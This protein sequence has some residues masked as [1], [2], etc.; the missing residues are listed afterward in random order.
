MATIASRLTLLA[1][2][3]CIVAAVLA[4]Y[5]R[6]AIL[7]PGH[8]ADRAVATLAQ[9]EVADEIATRFSTGVIERSPGLV[10]LRPA[11][12]AA[13]ADA[14]T[15]PR[16]AAEFGAGMRDLHR[17][18]F[19]GSD[20]RPALRVPGMAAAVRAAVAAR[21]PV[22]AQRL[23]VAADP[24][25]MS[26]GGNA[27]ERGLLDVASRAG[28][29]T[30]LAPVVLALGLLGLLLVAL[31]ARDRRRGLWASGLALA[32]A[33][34]TLV[35]GWM[36]ARTLTLQGFDTSWGD[37][38]VKTIWGAYLGDLRA[39]S[40][41]LA[42]AGILVAAAAARREHRERPS[43]A[44]VPAPLR[45]VAL[46]VTGAVVVA[47]RDLAL[48]LAAAAATGV[49]LYLG[50][51]HLLAGRAGIALA[52]AALLA[53]TAGVAVAASG[54]EHAPQVVA[55]AATTRPA[56]TAT[57]RG[58]SPRRRSAAVPSGSPRI[59]F[60]SMQDARAAAEGAAIPAG[61]VVKTLSDGRVCVRPR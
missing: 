16:F 47:D 34:G 31:S 32:G 6:S 20:P 13:A 30:R 22:L 24:S 36:A 50:A 18:V 7:D 48:D 59:C 39:W 5:A 41:G 4:L 17:G 19:T 23:P 8:F 46:L 58:R 56:P 2:A 14:V 37:A 43:W 61:A 26:I 27:R 35:A 55:A 21:T 60:A 25:L 54:P 42:G 40:L 10:T 57:T 3:A 44:R 52:A 49:L 51:R 1:S 28:G 11:L 29:P 33:G 53:L 45:G 12:E 38:V 9:D 15:S